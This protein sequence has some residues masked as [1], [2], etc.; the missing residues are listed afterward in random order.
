MLVLNA[1]FL[2]VEVV[3]DHVAIGR[4]HWFFGEQF[5][6]GPRIGLM[7]IEEYGFTLIIPY[8]VLVL[9]KLVEKRHS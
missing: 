5:L 9:Y 8:F 4:G 1:I 7:P 6:L 2:L 3:W